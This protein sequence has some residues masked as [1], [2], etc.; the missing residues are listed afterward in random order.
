MGIAEVMAIIEKDMQLA[1]NRPAGELFLS[2]ISYDESSNNNAYKIL[3]KWNEIKENPDLYE[4]LSLCE[5]VRLQLAREDI[6]E[7]EA[8]NMI[9]ELGC[10]HKGFPTEVEI[11]DYLYSEELEI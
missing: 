10:F 2:G 7:V 11:L 9:K 6:A 1:K 5:Q 8:I 3:K 4:F